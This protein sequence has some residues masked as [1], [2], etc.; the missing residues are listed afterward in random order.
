MLRRSPSRCRCRRA[1]G[2]RSRERAADAR[3]RPRG[4]ARACRS[5]RRRSAGGRRSALLATL[6]ARDARAAAST[7]STAHARHAAPSLDAAARPAR[8]AT[9]T[10]PTSSSRS[11]TTARAHA[12]LRRRRPR[13]AARRRHARSPRTYRVGNGSAGNVG[14]RGA[15]RTSSRDSGGVR[16]RVRQPAA[17]RRRHRPRGRRGGA[18]RRAR[19]PSAPRS[20]RS[21]RPTT[22]RPPS[23]AA[24]V[25]RAAAT[26]PLDRQLAHGLRH[27]RP[28]RRRARSTR[29][30]ETRLRRHLERFRMAGYDLEVD[31]P[32]FVA[33]DVALHV[34]VQPEL[35]P[36]PRAARGA[37]RAVERRAARR[38]ASAL[39]HPDNF[40]LRRA[41]LPEPRSSPP[42]RR[43]RASSRCAPSASSALAQPDAD[44]RSTNG[45]HRDGPARDRAARQRPELPR[46]RPAR[47]STVGRRQV[48][49][50]DQA[51]AARHRGL[52]LLRRRRRRARRRACQPRR[53]V[54]DR[55]PHRRLRATS[56]RACIAGLSSPTLPALA[57][58]A[59]ARRRRLHD[60]PARRLRL[61]RR[62]ADASTRSASPTSRYLRTATERISLQELARLIGYRLRP[63]VA[64][65]TWLAFALET[66]P[67][68]PAGAAA[69]A[70]APSS[71]ACRR[72]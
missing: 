26:L 29:R 22:P 3:L 46:A 56:A 43:C 41:G 58:A 63:G 27:R 2:R 28:R 53:P 4:A 11:R 20:A 31:A 38:H 21:P 6:T 18:P 48:S 67:T 15:S 62:R 12:A 52:R 34:C 57:A 51:V 61:R 44:R 72:R 50:P 64:A 55:L 37:R 17:G 47:R 14:A 1:S 71:P 23:G 7:R 49:Q 8:A 60:R 24:D 59:H 5:P 30:F 69:R 36:R 65:E 10:P 42:R 33:L 32:R 66:P 9:A 39:F 68:P 54:G 35:L 40:T 13:P 25:Q 16:S 19:R 70:R 45:V